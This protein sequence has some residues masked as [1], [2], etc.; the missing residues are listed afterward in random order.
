MSAAISRIS[1]HVPISGPSPSFIN[2]LH[3]EGP[4]PDRAGKM[5]LYGWLI[6]AWEMDVVVHMA[7]D[8]EY[9]GK[10][11]IHF[12]WVLE[13]RAIQDVWITPP[14]GHR[15][16]G[17]RARVPADFYGSTFRIYDPGIDAW[18]IFWLDPVKQFYSRMIGR[19]DGC[20]IEQLTVNETPQRRWRFSEITPN[21]FRWTA[22][23]DEGGDLAKPHWRRHVEFFARR[24]AG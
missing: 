15:D 21:A 1:A 11:E 19:A 7:N 22:D 9:R 14:R 18:H 2:A 13:G 8:A 4:A 5:G 20:D 3:A 16:D 23:V 12:G 17:N 24:V 6:G 10:G